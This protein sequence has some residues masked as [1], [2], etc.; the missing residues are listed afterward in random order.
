MFDL[1]LY[2][3]RGLNKQRL[4]RRQRLIMLP[5]CM[6]SNKVAQ[7]LFSTVT[8]YVFLR[9]SDIKKQESTKNK[10]LYKNTELNM[11]I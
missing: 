11:H 7:M 4:G 6:Y 2:E 5:V 1:S 3:K 9:L 8:Y 10:I